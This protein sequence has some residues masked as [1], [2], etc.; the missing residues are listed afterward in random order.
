MLCV[1][2]GVTYNEDISSIVDNMQLTSGLDESVVSDVSYQLVV[3]MSTME[4]VMADANIHMFH[5]DKWRAMLDTGATVT[6]IPMACAVKL[7][8]QIM[9]HTDGRRVGTADQE[10][11]LEI[12]GWLDL[13]GFIGRA[14]VCSA[15]GFIIVASCQLQ[16][17][18]LGMDL[19][20]D[21]NICELYTKDGLF[22]ILDQC[23]ATHLYYIDLRRLMN[24]PQCLYVQHFEGC[25]PDITYYNLSTPITINT[26]RKPT[27]SLSFK[28]FRFHRRFKHVPFRTLSRM[29]RQG[30]IIRVDVT[31]DEIDLVS[32]HQECKEVK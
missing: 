15:V 25:Q 19:K 17:C 12:Q 20:P 8:L 6:L 9:P 10:G 30:L 3:S 16:S 31:A 29:V 27:S 11:T 7:G 24:L 21:N 28:V 13:Q 18:G 4:V 2:V 23:S 32:A 22:A 26:H 14:A 1:N 5:L